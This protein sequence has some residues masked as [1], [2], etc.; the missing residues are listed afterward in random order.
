MSKSHKQK[1]DSTNPWLF[2]LELGYFAGL[3]WGGAR[4]LMYALH[5][6]KVV[7]G[8]LLEPFF[9]HDFLLGAAGQIAGYL[10]FIVFS[11][12]L[13]L[14]YVLTMRKLRGPWPGMIYGI[15]WWLVIFLAFPQ[16]FLLQRMFKLSWDS[17]I[18]EFCVFLLW[19]LFIGYTAAIE[20]TDERKREQSTK[21]V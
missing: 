20:Y 3:I 8:M 9:K 4:W 17:L 18:S 5:F 14:L 21:L 11:V 1:Q 13:S 16:W 19:G 7:P 15:L 12:V 6:T 10:S 2:A